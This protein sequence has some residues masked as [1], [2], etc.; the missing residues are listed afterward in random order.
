MKRIPTQQQV[1]I[2]NQS[3]NLYL[4]DSA[5]TNR[6]QR[7]YRDKLY[8]LERE[9]IDRLDQIK[10]KYITS[11]WKR[12]LFDHGKLRDPQMKAEIKSVYLVHE[13]S[14]VALRRRYNCSTDG[15]YFGK[16]IDCSVEVRERVSFLILDGYDGDL[17]TKL[18]EIKS[19]VDEERKKILEGL[20]CREEFE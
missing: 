7:I 17:S 8:K 2:F 5:I 18:I 9:S 12:F 14:C 15:Y 3:L 1:E 20:E 16:D 19:I 4:R 11:K 10:K 6:I 13:D